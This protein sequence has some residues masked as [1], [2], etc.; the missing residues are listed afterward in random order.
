MRKA[1][2]VRCSLG[3][4]LDRIIACPRSSPPPCW[5]FPPLAGTR[6]ISLF[7]FQRCQPPFMAAVAAPPSLTAEPVPITAPMP[8]HAHRIGGASRCP[9]GIRAGRSWPPLHRLPV[10]GCALI[11]R[12]VVHPVTVMAALARPRHR[13]ETGGER[14]C[15][16]RV[17]GFGGG[18]ELV[19]MGDEIVPFLPDDR[20]RF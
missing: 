8:D 2:S 3:V 16:G 14:L 9:D 1:A 10:S 15:R 6:T 4:D 7:A 19:G 17:D 13:P 5:R 12:S 11:R 18:G 20:K